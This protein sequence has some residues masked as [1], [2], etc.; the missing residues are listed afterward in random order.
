MQK[1]LTLILIFLNCVCD[2]NGRFVEVLVCCYEVVE[3]VHERLSDGFVLEVFWKQ[4]LP[5]NA[6]GFRGVWS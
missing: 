2:Y 6:R 4:H 3:N 1:G 5:L